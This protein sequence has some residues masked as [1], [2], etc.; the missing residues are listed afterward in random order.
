MEKQHV[1]GCLISRES[2]QKALTYVPICMQVNLLFTFT[3]CLVKKGELFS[4]IEI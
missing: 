4:I 2:N 1:F 3:F